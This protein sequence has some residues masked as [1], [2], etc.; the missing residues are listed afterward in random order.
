MSMF[1][2]FPWTVYLRFYV[3]IK[4]GTTVKIGIR[5]K[6]KFL[7]FSKRVSDLL[8]IKKSKT[9]V[10]THEENEKTFSNTEESVHKNAIDSE[11]VS[12]LYSINKNDESIDARET[13]KYSIVDEIHEDI[14]VE[15]TKESI[16]QAIAPYVRQHQLT[17]E[18]FDKIFDKY[19]VKIQYRITDFLYKNQY[20]LVDEFSLPDDPADT[21][22]DTK[23]KVNSFAEQKVSE[24]IPATERLNS[25]MILIFA[26][27]YLQNK[28]ILEKDF[29]KAF[30]FLKPE[31]QEEAK[32]ILTSHGIQIVS[33][34]SSQVV[35]CRKKESVLESSVAPQPVYIKKNIK[36]DNKTLVYLIQEGN[37]QAEQ[38]LCIKNRKLVYKYAQSCQKILGRKIDLEDIVQYGM[39]GMLEAA[40]K[41]DLSQEIEFSTYATFW[42]KQS[43]Y[44]NI[45]DNEFTIR[46][47]VHVFEK[48]AKI[49][50]A[51]QNLGDNIKYEDKISLLV[52]Q[53]DFSKEEIIKCLFL[54]STMLNLTSLDLPVGEDNDTPLSSL[55]PCENVESTEEQAMNNLCNKDIEKL[56][57]RCLNEREIKILRLRFGFADGDPHTLDEIG[58][59]FGVTRERIRQIEKRA[60]RRLRYSARKMKMRDY[61][62][63]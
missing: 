24:E 13:T 34:L 1:F 5:L 47:P 15:V 46:I 17:Y 12:V 58:K 32:N 43:I 41:F 16:L 18:D 29:V 26:D 35:E 60:I 50:K 28:E 52:Q 22:P 2:I 14:A 45:V 48:I 36:L 6:N 25:Q 49:W 54:G 57:A 7:D 40:K 55:I 27:P 3:I 38:D 37:K 23:Q 33:K 4:D 59:E 31:E 21:E 42:I 44:R 51:E 61:L 53:L 9:T 8:S 39:I 30:D 19:P 20:E 11:V 56:F 62:E 10:L 63:K